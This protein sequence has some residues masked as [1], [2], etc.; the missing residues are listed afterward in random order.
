MLWSD[1]PY[2]E[3]ISRFNNKYHGE[4]IVMK[5]GTK[6]GWALVALSI[7]IAVV[8]IVA[9]S[10]NANQQ[11]GDFILSDD[12]TVAIQYTGSGGAVTIP[13]GVVTL[14]DGLFM[15]FSSITSISMPSTVTSIGSSFASGCSQL[16]SVSL[17]SNIST[18]PS[19]AFRECSGLISISLPS[20]S[21]IGDNAF[22]GCASLGS[23]TIPASCTS[24]SD[25]AFSG[26]DNLE[27]IS[28]SSG[29][30]NYSSSDGCLYNAAKSRLIYV[31]GG[32]SSVTIPSTC[33]TIG[34]GAFR[35]AVYVTSITI[36]STVE[37]IESGA[38]SG[39]GITTIYG[40]A[41]SAAETYAKNNSIAFVVIGSDDPVDPVD[42]VNP[43]TS[44]TPVTPQDGDVD[45]GDGTIT[46][47]DGTVVEAATGRVIRAGTGSTG[48]N[49][50]KDATPGTADGVNP[51][52]FLCIAVFLGG[53]GT[54]V[55]T[56]VRKTRYLKR[57]K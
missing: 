27:E 16:Q 31:P 17:S 30:S 47:A 13:D 41:D 8:V 56:R 39:S 44:D 33:S 5:T 25:T 57:K 49:H 37:T 7:V 24:I 9:G 4:I 35:D 43:D 54:V 32:K 1:I 22:Y 14:E 20:V 34:S 21:S 29:N 3:V 19:N 38:L 52:Y 26:C 28:V 50:A 45:N 15:N 10:T 2:V 23:I 12:G 55:Y 6:I 40:Y 42:P 46:R 18:I 11:V 48:S 36:P 53:A 51:V